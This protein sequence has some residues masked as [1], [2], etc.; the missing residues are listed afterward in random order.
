MQA[1]RAG[2]IVDLPSYDPEELV[3]GVG[4]D[5]P[6]EA[7]EITRQD[8]MDGFEK[9]AHQRRARR[10]RIDCSPL[11]SALAYVAVAASRARRKCASHSRSASLTP[12]PDACCSRNS[13]VT[14]IGTSLTIA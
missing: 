13:G 6:F 8:P 10:G 11:P 9:G 14:L 1:E 12:S 2:R 7:V 5:L 3:R 4:A